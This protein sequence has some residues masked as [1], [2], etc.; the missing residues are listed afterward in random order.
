MSSSVYPIL[1]LDVSTPIAYACLFSSTKHI[2]HAQGKMG[3]QH[4]QTVLPLLEG[5][6]KDADITWADLKLLVLGQGPG[7]FTGL[8][9]AAASISGINASLKLPIWGISSLAI[10]AM[11]VQSD[12]II[13]VVEDARAHEIFLGCYQKGIAQKQDVCVHI[14]NLH[15]P[16][17][18]MP[19]VCN[20]DFRMP[21]QNWAHIPCVHD[22]AHAM[23]RLIQ[24]N[25]ENI[26]TQ[27]LPTEVQPVYLQLSQAE[28]QLKHV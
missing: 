13:W 23:S 2:F 15:T 7:S 17:T 6:L 9:I 4:S 26:N 1:A 19:Y 16:S 21:E 27:A 28:R 8:R 12:K 11:Q 5:L 3:K 14:E 25:I 18:P 24:Q 22:R 20:S 10:T